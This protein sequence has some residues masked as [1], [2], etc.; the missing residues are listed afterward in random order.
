MRQ[1]LSLVWGLMV[2]EVR[3]GDSVVPSALNALKASL[4]LPLRGR[5]PEG[6][7]LRHDLGVM[8]A[9]S[10]MPVKWG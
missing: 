9:Q 3:G 7:Q 2:R 6:Q 10:K 8:A 4:A 5:E 1:G